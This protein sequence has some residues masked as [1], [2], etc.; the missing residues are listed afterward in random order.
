MIKTIKIKLKPT[1]EQLT[2]LENYL[3]ISQ[4]VYNSALELK[5]FMWQQR[6]ENVSKFQLYRDIKHFKGID[7]FKNIPTIIIRS[8]ID[9][10]DRSFQNFF[11]GAGYPKF[12]NSHKSFSVKYSAKLQDNFLKI[13][14]MGKIE[15]SKEIS[16]ET[17]I[18]I[19]QIKKED[20]G[21]F[22]CIT[23]DDPNIIP[24]PKTFKSVGIDVGIAILASTS[25]NQLITNH[26]YYT[27]YQNK[28]KALQSSLA[29]REKG[30]RRY[31]LT[32]NQIR[33]IHKK[34]ANC[35]KDYLHKISLNLVKNYDLIVAEDLKPSQMVTNS[36]KRH[37]NKSIYDASWSTLFDMIDYKSKWYGKTFAKVKPHY[38]SRDCNLCKNRVDK[39]PLS[40]REWKCESCGAIN[41]RDFNA[42]KN[43]LDKY[44]EVI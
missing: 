43:I 34:I 36:K 24:F 18:K 33:K 44:L 8:A 26:K 32:L 11:R 12:S 14:N 31:N 10:I 28:L 27:K 40:V 9:R 29:K 41:H 1:K 7:S 35:R 42:A 22:A 21:W 19:C 3:N 20:N 30:S 2:T 37:L 15:L 38:T 23:Y 13:P 5:I 16:I 39:L 17:P 6:R 25:D 4:T